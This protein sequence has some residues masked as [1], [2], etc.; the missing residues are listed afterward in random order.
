MYVYNM[1]KNEQSSYCLIVTNENIKRMLPTERTSTERQGEMIADIRRER[2]RGDGQC[3]GKPEARAR[4][5]LQ[6]DTH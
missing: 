6:L 2:E 4:R 5:Y 3:Y 1:Y